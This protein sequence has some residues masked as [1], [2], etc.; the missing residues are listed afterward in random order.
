M[1]LFEYA[2]RDVF[3]T[4][5]HTRWTSVMV[6][7]DMLPRSVDEAARDRHTDAWT[8]DVYK[9]AATLAEYRPDLLCVAVDTDAHRPAASSSAPTPAAPV[10]PDAYDGSTPS[11]SCRTPSRCPQDVLTRRH[12]VD[13]K[14]FLAADFWHEL[15]HARDRVFGRSGGF[16]QLRPKIEAAVRDTSRA[17]VSVPADDRLGPRAQW[18]AAGQ[19]VGDGPGRPAQAGRQSSYARARPGPQRVA[20]A[21]C[22]ATGPQRRRRRR[23]LDRLGDGSQR[24]RPPPVSLEADAERDAGAAVDQADLQPPASGPDRA[25]VDVGVQRRRAGRVGHEPGGAGHRLRVA[26]VAGQPQRRRDRGVELERELD[27]HG[28]SPEPDARTDDRPRS[29][30]RAS[31]R[32]CASTVATSRARLPGSVQYGVTTAGGLPTS[33]GRTASATPWAR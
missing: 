18:R 5:R 22:G 19:A 12:A 33:A 4:E 1:H 25:G 6:L 8:G 3:H 27:G 29:G 17:P 30:V 21:A 11:T 23:A 2:L 26:A 7:D 28:R 15:T 24:R 13:P 32:S 10:L 9:V 20:G 14:A 31:R 16:E